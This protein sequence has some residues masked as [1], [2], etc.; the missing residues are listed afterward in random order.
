MSFYGKFYNA[1]I[2]NFA[3][4]PMSIPEFREVIEQDSS[5]HD[6]IRARCLL[7]EIPSTQIICIK[8]KILL[9]RADLWFGKNRPILLTKIIEE[10]FPNSQR[11]GEPSIFS[12]TS[13]PVKISYKEAIH[14]E[15]LPLIQQ[16]STLE[17]NYL[18]VSFSTMILGGNLLME[19]LEK[20]RNRMLLV[21][22][23]FATLSGD[24][25]TN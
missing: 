19:I 20:I 10:C 18:E 17:L 22:A 11:Q 21:S 15:G 14:E 23:R 12:G 2:N 6:A 25:F 1:M 5:T 24:H 3:S 16:V 8:A 9:A 7:T 13:S 4:H